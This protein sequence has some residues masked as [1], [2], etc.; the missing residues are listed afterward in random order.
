VAGQMRR[1]HIQV[2][3]AAQPFLPE[4]ILKLA[5]DIAR[6]ERRQGKRRR[7]R[8]G[9]SRETIRIHPP[10]LTVLLGCS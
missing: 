5:R 4:W 10:G 2:P 3:R 9:A 8:T 6:L 1:F 7:P